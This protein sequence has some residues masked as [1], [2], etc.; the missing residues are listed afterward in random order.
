M[1]KTALHSAHVDGGAKMTDFAGWDLPIEY[2]GAVGETNAVRTNGGIFDVSHMG[3]IK[4]GGSGAARLLDYILSCDVAALAVGQ[5]KYNMLCNTEGGIID[6]CIVYC[7]ADDEYLLIVNAARHKEDM[8]WILAKREE[9]KPPNVSIVDRTAE[10]ALIAVQGPAVAEKMVEISAGRTSDIKRF[11]A[12]P[13]NL[14]GLDGVEIWA[15]RTGY[16]GEDGFE[17]VV[18]ADYAERIWRLL[19]DNGFTPCGL[20]ARDVLRLETGL[21]LY[22]N[23]ATEQ[24]NP[25]ECGLGWTVKLAKTAD[26]APREALTVLKKSPVRLLGF[27]VSKGI[28]RRGMEIFD[29]QGTRKVGTVTSGT[30]SPTIKR[31]IGFGFFDTALEI[32]TVVTIDL[33]GRKIQSE[34]VKPP[35]YK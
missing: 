23:D 31:G 12:A 14:K 20:A 5:A 33:R 25:Y 1:F 30:Y 3:R 26:Y 16:T 2:G 22:G 18:P 10:T 9:L 13:I 8:E 34:I 29:A 19:I 32:G 35:F 28:P 7:V 15:G 24:N 6:D 21:I 27:K 11:S 17:L 4:F